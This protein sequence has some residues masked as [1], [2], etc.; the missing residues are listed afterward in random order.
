MIDLVHFIRPLW[1]TALPLIGLVWWLVRRRDAHQSAVGAFLPEHLR[2]ALTVHRSAR[3]GIRAVD[4]VSLGAALLAIAAAGPAWQTMRDPWFAETAPLVVAIEVSDS[5]R[6]NDLL[7][8]RL[9]RARFKVLDLLA[10]RTGARTALIAYSGSAHIVMPPTKDVT[11][12]TPFLESLDPAIM[13]QPGANAAAVLPLA[14][15]LLVEPAMTGTLLFVNDGFDPADIPA[16]SDFAAEPGSPVLA[17]LV[18]GTEAGGVALMPDGTPV[19]DDAG[20]RL[21]T[22]LDTGTLARAASAGGVAVVR[23]STGD[24]DVRRLL[25]VL[26]SSLRQTAEPDARWRDEGW[27]LLW[28]AAALTLLW[29]RRGWTMRW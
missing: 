29:F 14:R 2:D 3:S 13:P 19:R 23:A 6:S 22:R 8:S 4:G 21:D 20:R 5:M 17:A 28:P 15:S 9:D 7:P 18:L 1:L 11:L 25:R 24:A 12:L 26:E 16:L 27:W 10:L